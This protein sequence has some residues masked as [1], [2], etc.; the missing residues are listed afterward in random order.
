MRSY[1]TNEAGRAV[2]LS[3]NYLKRLE[4]EG[5]LE[6]VIGPVARTRQGYRRYTEDQVEKLRRHFKNP[7]RFTS[8]DVARLAGRHPN[9][10]RRHLASGTL[11]EVLGEVELGPRRAEGH[12]R[13]FTREQAERIAAW[14]R[15]REE[16]VGRR[17]PKP[18]APSDNERN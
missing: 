10:V 1:G 16:K 8:G 5:A 14:Y 2:G 6:P 12:E 13:S 15:E 7:E 3:P 11:D 9:T 18:K 4:A 17:G